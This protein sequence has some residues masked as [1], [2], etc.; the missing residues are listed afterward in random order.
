MQINRKASGN[1]LQSQIANVIFFATFN[2]NFKT[3]KIILLLLL[4]FSFYTHAQ[5]SFSK[6]YLDKL[7]LRYKLTD[8]NDEIGSQ[9]SGDF[10][11][12]GKEDLV[13]IL[14]DSENLGM[15]NLG[16]TSIF[17]SSK[18]FTDNSYQSFEWIWT[19]NYLGDFSCDEGIFH[20][21]GGSVSQGLFSDI[22]LVY[23][24]TL[25]KMVVKSYEDS[26]GNTTFDGLKSEQ[27]K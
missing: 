25:G 3:M 20:I 15:E 22:V 1:S 16:M 2:E 14:F 19:G 11:S 5:S 18:F 23:N 4:G 8:A 9:C 7:P 21:S 27:I 26:N 12:D 24:K 13:V 6:Q 10:D 17:L